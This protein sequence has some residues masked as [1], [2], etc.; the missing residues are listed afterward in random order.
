MKITIFGDIC[1]TKDTFVAFDRGNTLAIFGDILKEIELSDI[2]IGNLECAVTDNPKPIQKSGPI[3]HTNTRSIQTLKDFDVLSLANNHIRD[4]GDEG[5]MTALETCKKLGICTLGAGEDIQAARQPLV[6]EKNGMK[7]GVISFAEQEFN[8]A[9]DVR[10]GACFLDLYEDFDRIREFRKTIDYLIILYHG[11]IEYFPYASPELRKKCRKFVDCGADIV[12]CQHSHCIGTIEHYKGRV[13]VY[14]QGNSVFGYRKGNISWNQGLLLQVELREDGSADV[15]YKGITAS[16]KGLM[17][18]SEEKSRVL[19]KQLAERNVKAE[20][21]IRKEWNTF[22]DKLG[23]IHMPLLFGWP[24]LLIA[25]N[26]RTDNLLL[27]LFMNK[28]RFNNTHNLIRCEAHREV[29]ETLLAKK[30]FL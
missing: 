23:K 25:I 18:L 7:V 4:C 14:G 27:K 30:D 22:C 6:I 10:P 1:P 24:K 9:T 26:R 13:I 5:V 8:T 21:D 16:T 3:L 29:I 19:E 11:G 28:K 17:F 12:T 20:E 2:V 15:S